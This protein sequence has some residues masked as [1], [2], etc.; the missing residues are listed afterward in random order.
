MLTLMVVDTHQNKFNSIQYQKKNI[1]GFS[2]FRV[3]GVSIIFVG[4]Y[5]NL[6]TFPYRA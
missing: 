6:G 1:I 3:T 2:G 4:S 5:S